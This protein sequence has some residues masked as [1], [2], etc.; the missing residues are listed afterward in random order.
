M[1]KKIFFIILLLL[2]IILTVYLISQTTIFSGKA[3]NNNSHLP[4]KENSYLFASPLQA[5]ADGL[6]KIR[7]TVFLLDSDGIGVNQQKV[8][9]NTSPNIQIESLQ[10]ITDDTGKAIFNLSSNTTGKYSLSASTSTLNLTQKINL[11]FL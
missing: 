11:L 10:S 6:E 1:I 4:N 9:L 7:I 2:G 3:T 8:I 5:K